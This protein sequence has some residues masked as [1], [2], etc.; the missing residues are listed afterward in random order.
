MAGRR[1]KITL[2]RRDVNR[3]SRVVRDAERGNRNHK[4]LELPRSADETEIRLG[5]ISAT[6]S[7]GTAAT[8]TQLKPDG[9]ALT[10]ERTFSADNWFADITVSSG[11][12]RVACASLGG[13][14]I[15]IA[16]EC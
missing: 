9:T 6:W 7:K 13:G 4:T 2:R 11:T 16:A 12:K 5:T 10:T 3:I 1:E 14:W 15:L 8:V